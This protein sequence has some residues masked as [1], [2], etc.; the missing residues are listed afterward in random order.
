M[1]EAVMHLADDKSL[2]KSGGNA[3]PLNNHQKNINDSETMEV[4]VTEQNVQF[5]QTEL[6][7]TT[8]QQYNDS[9]SKVSNEERK[10]K[11][12]PRS[13]FVLKHKYEKLKGFKIYA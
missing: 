1:T 13:N 4:V 10:P 11:L 9:A 3:S 2:P 12:L 6:A 5:R 8:A 7:T